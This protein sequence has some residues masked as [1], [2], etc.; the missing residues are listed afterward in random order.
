MSV[1]PESV[2]QLLDSDNYGDRIRGVNQLRLLDPAI[3]FTKIKT[4]VTDSNVRVRYAAVS[5]LCTLG[6]ENLPESL[7]ILGDRLSNDP[8]IDV[9]SAA[10]D[11]LGALH[12]TEAYPQLEQAYY[13]TQE[14]LLQM[15]VVAT[16][17]ELGD[18]RALELLKGALDSPI[19]LV[20]T[21]A[22]SSLG[23]LGDRQAIT[24][25]LP[26]VDDPDWQMRH[27]VAQ[28]LQRFGGEE[29]QSALARLAKDPVE[30]VV[31]AALTPGADSI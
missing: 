23:E 21:A 14:W 19:D 25:L 18:L 2:Q 8:E 22:A 31:V 15:S 27:R 13:G 29:V 11:A 17:G 12:L 26:L 9:K 24:W 16:L 20:R 1:T 10:A 4:L 30:Q 5:Q 6:T 3:A 28:A 7:E